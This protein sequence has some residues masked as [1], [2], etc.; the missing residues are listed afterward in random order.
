MSYLPR[1]TLI[2]SMACSLALL[3]SGQALAGDFA[4]VANGNFSATATWDNLGGGC[5]GSAAGATV[6]S[7]SAD[8]ARICASRSVTLDVPATVGVVSVEG[9]GATLALGSNV[10]TVTTQFTVS[11]SAT[12]TS[13]A[14]VHQ[15]AT[16][17]TVP[18]GGANPTVNLGNAHVTGNVNSGAGSITL[19]SG[20]VVG[21]TV[22]ISGAGTLTLTAG[23]T[24]GGNVITYGSGLLGTLK[25]TA[26]NKTI[27]ASS[28]ATIPV[29]DLSL[30]TIG[31]T[32]TTMTSTVTFGSVTG[33]KLE[34]PA[35]TPYSAGSAI[36]AGTTC[37]VVAAPIISAPIDLN[38]SKTPEIF[39][40]EIE[41][42]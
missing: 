15:L 22:L 18:A 5:P 7:S 39:A 38:F 13:G 27:I 19:G 41:L 9:A 26:G 10:L 31:Q 1:F 8:T 29:L 3:A 37:T 30:M 2:K 34:C 16:V 24:V 23:A 14:T 36:P 40:T 12:V 11:A 32:I 28:A 42:K 21:G 35:A 33:K 20:A 4:S 6:P 25:F 17:Q